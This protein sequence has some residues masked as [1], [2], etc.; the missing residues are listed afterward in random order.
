MIVQV[1]YTSGASE[2]FT[3]VTVFTIE[4]DVVTIVGVDAAGVAA[5]YKLRWSLITKISQ[6]G[7]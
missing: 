1:Y 2:S 6:Q 5:T 7:G 3:S 4:G